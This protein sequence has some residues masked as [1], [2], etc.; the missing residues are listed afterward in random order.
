MLSISGK[1][2]KEK[3]MKKRKEVLGKEGKEEEKVIN[4]Y[5]YYDKVNKGWQPLPTSPIPHSSFPQAFLQMA[6]TVNQ[7]MGGIPN[8]FKFKV[9]GPSGD[10]RHLGLGHRGISVVLIHKLP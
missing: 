5:D 10:M 9:S 1:G 7:I 8:Y 6:W 4:G 3:T 2:K